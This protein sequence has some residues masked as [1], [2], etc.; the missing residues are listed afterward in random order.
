MDLYGIK[1]MNPGVSQI[2]NV[3]L[4]NLAAHPSQANSFVGRIYFNTVDNK[5]Y[6]CTNAT[7]PVYVALATGG[8]ASAL[9]TEVDAIETSLGGMV[10]SSGVFQASAFSGFANVTTP[11]SLTNVLS[12]LDTAIEGKD[13]LA[14]LDDVT[15]T[16][17][18]AGH[19]LYYTTEWVNAAPGATSGVQAYDAGLTSIAGLTTAADKMI[20]T[21]GSDTYAVTDLTAFGRS[22]VDDVDASA[23]RT[24]LGVV[25]GTDVQAYDAGLSA[26]ASFNTNG[27]IVQTADNTYVGRSV[28]GTAG[29]IV[30]TNGDGVAGNATVNLDTVSQAA[31]GSFVKV[32]LDSY[33]R[34]S[35]NTA[36][37]ASDITTLVD[38]TYVNVSGDT[39][40]G[41]LAMG[42]NVITGLG[43]GTAATDAVNKGQLDA[44]IAGLSWK[45]PVKAATTANITLSGAQTIDGVSIV[46]TDR[47]LVKNQSTASE[48]GIYVAAAGAWTRS[49]D[50]DSLS[51]IDEINSAAV[52]VM[53][54]TT[55]GDY[56]FTVTS[57]VAVLDTD[58]IVWAQ[59]TGASAIV[60]GVG[61]SQS[62][63]TIDVLLGAGIA[64]LPSDEVGIDIVSGKAVQLTSSLTGGQL[65]FVLDGSTM[66]Q[67]G[68]GLKIAAAGVTE[69]ELNTSVAGNG[70]AG[71]GG[72]ALSVNVDNSTIEI[73]ADSLRIKGSGVTNGHLANSTITVQG[74][75]GTNDPV[76]LG[77][78]LAFSGGVGVVTNAVGS[79][80]VVFDFDANDITAAGADA[81]TGD[82]FVAYDSSATATR[83]F[84]LA[85]LGNGI[86]GEINFGD[87]ADVGTAPA[88]AGY[89]VV[90]DG[91]VFNSKKIM[92]KTALLSAATSHVVTHSLNQRL[93][94]V[95]V[96]DSSYNQIIPNNIALDSTTQCTISF[97]SNS[98]SCYIVV[99]GVEGA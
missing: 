87:L 23:A 63:N 29:N 30:V 77:E 56:A 31:S 82:K 32:T 24:T 1:L 3:N 49:S 19:V 71:G 7:G 45:N 97:G 37:V 72:T 90:G 70:L 65:T 83:T 84:T 36:V 27:F 48:N 17:P 2:E 15:I 38:S 81:A 66:T 86:A 22:L 21:T 47:V 88:T 33:G 8:D 60:A 20:Y 73:N 78:F 74:D 89:A 85:E 42:T 61:L 14:E 6:Y 68:T 4:E 50:F 16:T 25:I 64:Q 46:A 52:F 98:V 79:N 28:A 53:Q 62:G 5:F 55:N 94:L 39:M 75:I 59:F 12:Q 18:A 11:T 44:A 58:S 67:S 26:L 93:V 10:N 40:S 80:T 54:G 43:A 13:T 41:N 9:Q 35:G 76:A 99:M 95:Q 57:T 69:V 92:H 96:Y 91:S 34:V 51:P